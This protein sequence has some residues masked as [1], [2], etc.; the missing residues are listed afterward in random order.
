MLAAYPMDRF[1]HGGGMLGPEV[2]RAQ[3]VLLI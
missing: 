1:T 3:W 2:R